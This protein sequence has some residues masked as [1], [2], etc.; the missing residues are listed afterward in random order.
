MRN[1][2]KN[3]DRNAGIKL[4]VPNYKKWIEAEEDKHG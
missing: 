4:S 2:A 3:K 1:L